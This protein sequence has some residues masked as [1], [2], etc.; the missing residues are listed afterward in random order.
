[1]QPRGPIGV[2]D[3]GV[4]GLSVLRE[5]RRELPHERTV[6]VADSGFAPY[7]D[8]DA[9]FIERR[10][11]AIVRFL[12][13]QGVKAIVVACNTATGVAVER[14]RTTYA[15]P[16][17][18]IEPAVKPAAAA[19]RSGVIAVLA[20]SATLAS[21]RFSS[22]VGRHG[23]TVRVIVQPCPGLAQQVESGDLAGA[24]TRA[25]VEQYV[26]PLVGHDVDT[27]VIGCTHYT[28]LTPIIQQVAGDAVT[29]VDPAAA[30]A[31]ELRR[32]LDAAGL[33]NPASGDAGQAGEVFWTS[34]ELDEAIRVMAQLWAP[35]TPV[36]PLPAEYRA[37][38]TDGGA[39]DP[40][41]RRG[42]RVILRRL[43]LADLPAFQAYRHDP[44]VGRYQGWEPQSDVAASR[45]I[46]EMRAVPLFPVGTWVQLGIAD[47]E[48]DRLVGDVGV[49]VSPDGETAEVGITV[50]TTAQGSGRAAD[51]LRAG[52]QLV[53]ERTAVRRVVAVTDE[54]NAAALKLLDR[55]GMTLVESRPALFRG[56]PCVEYGFAIN[57]PSSS[58][59]GAA[60]PG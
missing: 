41:P 53:F 42:G 1:V 22:L 12:I 9:D 11:D 50:A 18:A 10:S 28:F 16:I 31:R 21:A 27:L 57:R 15:L 25:L 37:G 48:T 33:L 49:S 4:G 5:I 20:T 14:L 39:G 32:R 26:A 24:K 2:F 40:L 60:P 54:R 45:F 7:G 58:V 6:Y 35:A 8:R 52:I 34:G 44:L 19:T 51:A 59:D 46:M 38:P 55:V 23:G 29:V 47:A 3:S 17:V 13:A 56:E 43:S 36:R 30:V